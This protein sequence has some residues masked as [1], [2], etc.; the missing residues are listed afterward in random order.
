MRATVDSML[1][2][3]VRLVRQVVPWQFA[4]REIGADADLQGDLGMDSLGKLALAL[5]VEQEFRIDLSS[6]QTDLTSIR[7]VGD[8]VGVVESMTKGGGR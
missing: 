3:V 4:K 7:T 1:D 5:R 6:L 8:V 2:R